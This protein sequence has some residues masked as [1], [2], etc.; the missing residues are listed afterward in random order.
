MLGFAVAVVMAGL[1]G[2]QQAPDE[3]MLDPRR[4]TFLHGPDGLSGFAAA[5]ERLGVTVERNRRAMF[6]LADDSIAVDRDE[7]LVM[8]DVGW[9]P[10]PQESEIRQVVRYLERGGGVM[11]LGRTGVEKCFGLRLRDVR[12][13]DDGHESQR[14]KSDQ[15]L[16]KRMAL[17]V[18]D[19]SDLPAAQRV[20]RPIED[21]VEEGIRIAAVFAESSLECEIS[22]IVEQ[23]AVLR[24]VS[25]ETVAWRFE[26]TG[27]GRALLLADSR[28]LSN[29][30]LRETDAGVAILPLLLAE[31][32]VTVRF[33]EYH[34]GFG[35]GGSI[36]GAAWGWLR[37]SPAGWVLL[38]LI[39]ATS[40]ALV[41]AAIRFGPAL[42]VVERRR[43]SPIEHL[44]ALAIGLERAGGRE[45]A[46]RLIVSGLRRR[47]SRAGVV[48]R[49]MSHRLGEWLRSLEL[50]ARTPSARAAVR[51]LGHLLHE[52]G[53]D[54]HVLNAALAVEEVWEAL[55]PETR[56]RK[57]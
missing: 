21:E 3:A 45:I 19:G 17:A 55:R 44:D 20:Y 26:V 1:A 29:R 31:R 37:R 14:G 15:T 13:L 28:Y 35:V 4:S 2:K 57:S 16:R 24:T 49:N 25:G 11:L 33:D 42:R 46:I 8:L 48:A 39:V 38:Q 34:L 56:S 53:S 41:V 6:H 47:L 43:R 12:S 51:R 54:I 22:G 18:A 9:L 10:L 30:V 7:W 23:R 5:L 50:A 27:R 32:P 40:V 36:F 52:R